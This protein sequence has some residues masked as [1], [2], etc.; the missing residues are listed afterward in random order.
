MKDTVLITG[1][2]SGLGRALAII[3]AKNGYDLILTA[4]NE[5]QLTALQTELTSTYNVNA[6]VF[7][8]DLCDKD[9]AATL[10]ADIERSG[11]QVDILVNNAGFGDFGEFIDRDLK[12]QEDMVQLNI[13]ALMQLAHLA[14]QGMR[15]RRHGR[16]LNVASIAA[17]QAG[18]L[19]SVY[20]ATKA[21]V[22]SFSQALARELKGSGITVTALCPGPIKTGFESAADLGNSRLF[23][24][25]PVATAEDVAAYGYKVTIKGKTVAV[26]GWHCKLLVFCVRLVPRRLV[27][28]IICKI[29]GKIKE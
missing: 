24:S 12:K 22:L 6:A 27:A 21:F 10:M 1:A 18:P 17:F 16:I 7:P 26:H 13:T 5:Q 25:I 2:S 11:L 23:R 19:M 28:D 4:R 20:Y 29:Q 9:A 14:L 15:E 3:F 8:V